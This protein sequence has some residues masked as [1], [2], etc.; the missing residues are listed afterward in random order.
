MRKN[1]QVG[2]VLLQLLEADTG[3]E[4]SLAIFLTIL[5]SRDNK[6][7]RFCEVVFAR[8]LTLLT[9]NEINS[10][11][12][13]FFCQD[14]DQKDRQFLDTGVLFFSI[15]HS[16]WKDNLP[17]V[18]PFYGEEDHWYVCVLMLHVCLVEFWWWE[19][20]I[21]VLIV[22]IILVI[23]SSCKMQRWQCSPP[24]TCWPRFGIWLCKQGNQ[25]N[26]CFSIRCTWLRES[27]SVQR[28]NQVTLW[29]LSFRTV[30]FISRLKS[31]RCWILESHQTGL[32]L[33]THARQLDISS[34]FFF[35][36]TF[37]VL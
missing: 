30:C 14:G 29:L 27:C 6:M 17:R 12:A 4:A 15:R 37:F 35:N 20:G 34:K 24:D 23:L 19:T 22:G 33:P 32:C 2:E 36:C 13:I 28:L 5:F 18:K 16:Q 25:C 9:L 10:V 8:F 31:K 3:V 26:V 21:T 1:E 7:V 11:V